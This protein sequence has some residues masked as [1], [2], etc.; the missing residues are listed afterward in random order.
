MKKQTLD[1]AEEKESAHF[2]E[3]ANQSAG[4]LKEM[5]RGRK[6]FELKP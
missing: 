2:C 4:E 5:G 3:K 1:I 6:G